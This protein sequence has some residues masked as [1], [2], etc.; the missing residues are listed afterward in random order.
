MSESSR[1]HHNMNYMCSLMSYAA[2][3]GSERAVF[4]FDKYFPEDPV[5]GINSMGET[6]R[7]YSVKFK[8]LP[9]K[10]WRHVIQVLYML[11]T[12]CT[13]ESLCNNTVFLLAMILMDTII[14][15]KGFSHKEDSPAFYKLALRM[16][17]APEPKFRMLACSMLLRIREPMPEFFAVRFMLSPQN[18][19]TI[20]ALVTA[21]LH[22][23]KIECLLVTLLPI[24]RSVKESHNFWL[25]VASMDTMDPATLLRSFS[26][27]YLCDLAFAY[28]V[29]KCTSPLVL[30]NAFEHPMVMEHCRGLLQLWIPPI[31]TPKLQSAFDCKCTTACG[32]LS[33]FCHRILFER[34]FDGLVIPE[35]VPCSPEA[36]Q[37]IVR[38]MYSQN[39]TE[40]V[41]LAACLEI[42]LWSR[43]HVPGLL[44]LAHILELTVMKIATINDLDL[45]LE[46]CEKMQ[47]CNLIWCFT[48]ELAIKNG[49]FQKVAHMIPF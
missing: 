35:S 28:F 2:E 47:T 29:I 11:V 4:C 19:S 25:L 34:I 17:N 48:Q 21:N 12:N 13:I 27:K 37:I 49:F 10:E 1:T 46:F 45:L 43:K 16:T 23:G 40:Q 39:I 22:S 5:C 31:Y 3:K 33:L 36:L 8:I 7:I 41:S 26:P 32:S 20:R 6:F 42:V 15:I 24:V 9:I 30:A 18:M 44:E 38:S 14:G